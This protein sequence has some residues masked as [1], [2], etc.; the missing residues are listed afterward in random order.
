MRILKRILIIKGKR[1]K[2]IEESGQG[3]YWVRAIDPIMGYKAGEEF[4][5]SKEAI[6]QNLTK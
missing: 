6:I 4:L 5:L 1:V 3:R 2:V